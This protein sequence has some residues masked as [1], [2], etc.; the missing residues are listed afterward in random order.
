[1]SDSRSRSLRLRQT[2]AAKTVRFVCFVLK[3]YICSGILEQPN[4]LPRIPGEAELS[5]GRALRPATLGPQSADPFS[6]GPV[7]G[8]PGSGSC[9]VCRTLKS[10]QV[11]HEGRAATA[12]PEG[13]TCSTSYQPK[14]AD[15]GV[16]PKV[17]EGP[18]KRV[19][20]T[21]EGGG[22]VPHRVVDLAGLGPRVNASRS[23]LW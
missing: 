14:A 1:M 10:D 9:Q 18:L 16:Q 17:Q 15:T 8:Q 5:Q 2:R 21:R 13:K 7:P 11:G 6:V 22:A 19:S 3:A 20:G 12:R 4:L 23:S